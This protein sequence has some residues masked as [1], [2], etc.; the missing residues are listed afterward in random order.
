VE[1]NGDYLLELRLP[2]DK[3]LW[4]GT[5][6]SFGE[7]IEVIEPKELKEELINKCNAFMLKNGD[8]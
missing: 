1:E 2:K 8:R 5:L 7:Q 4:K 3:T 6:I